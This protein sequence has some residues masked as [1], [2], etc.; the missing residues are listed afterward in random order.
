MISESLPSRVLSLITC[1]LAL[2]VFAVAL[3]G[4]AQRLNKHFDFSQPKVE[5]SGG[6]VAA[7]LAGTFSEPA[8]EHREVTVKGNP[9]ELVITFCQ[10]AEPKVRHIEVTS[11]VLEDLEGGLRT[12]LT[13][14]LKEGDRTVALALAEGGAV[15]RLLLNLAGH[16]VRYSTQTLRLGFTVHG[17][18]QAEYEVEL[19]FKT[20]YRE[21]ESNDSWD[22]TLSV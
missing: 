18:V 1:L 13:P 16:T 15:G 7:T 9:Y 22:K 19:E 8:S 14:F 10:E 2:S 17:G 11:L 21:F 3:A 6:Y 20:N 5:I 4:C 12:D